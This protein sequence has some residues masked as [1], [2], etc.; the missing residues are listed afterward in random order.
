M[1]TFFIQ[2]QAGRF[3]VLLCV[4][5]LVGA[6]LALV[7]PLRTARAAVPMT[8]CQRE[9]CAGS[10]P[11]T[12]GPGGVGCA[13]ID[14]RIIASTPIMSSDR[15]GHRPTKQATLNL[16]YSS[17]CGTNW[18]QVVN[19]YNCRGCPVTGGSISV[20]NHPEIRELF[21]PENFNPTNPADAE[22]DHTYMVYSPTIPVTVTVTI[23][24]GN[25]PASA[26]I[27]QSQ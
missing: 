19:E 7:L 20:V 27:T 26:T 11:Q 4:A 23:A 12:A 13:T 14:G 21:R 6:G 25:T 15:L 18:G 17:T 16:W 10:D 5:L 3:L 8:N 9:G 2:H 24:A 1:N 22:E